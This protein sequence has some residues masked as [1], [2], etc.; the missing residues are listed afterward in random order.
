M[1]KTAITCVVI[2]AVIWIGFL[3]LASK[4]FVYVT[5]C[6][7]SSNMH[8]EYFSNDPWEP[9]VVHD[10]PSDLWVIP[11][12]GEKRNEGKR[13]HSSWDVMANAQAIQN[14]WI[15]KFFKG[16]EL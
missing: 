9:F 15:L 13:R 14:G 11:F 7:P 12:W 10:G 2:I 6:S 4:K 8:I 5:T 3:W 16:E 1:W